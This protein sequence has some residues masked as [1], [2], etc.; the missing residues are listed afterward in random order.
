MKIKIFVV[1]LCSFLSLMASDNDSRE[2]TLDLNSSFASDSSKS[3]DGFGDNSQLRRL[4]QNHLGLFG[5]YFKTA[6]KNTDEYRS[7]HGLSTKKAFAMQISGEAD[8]A[9]G[10]VNMV[11]KN[12]SYQHV[13]R[14]IKV[15]YA[16]APRSSNYVPYLNY[17]QVLQNVL[18]EVKN[19]I[20]NAWIE[21]IKKGK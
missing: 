20:E 1:I 17:P 19:A 3:S 18:D 16:R 2:T 9:Q 21:V 8:Q 7:V 12:Q 14:D 11:D 5:D 15:Y 4:F 6:C 13:L 10:A